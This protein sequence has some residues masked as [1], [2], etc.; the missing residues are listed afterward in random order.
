MILFLKFA[1]R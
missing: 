1:Q